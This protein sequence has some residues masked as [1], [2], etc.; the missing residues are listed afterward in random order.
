MLTLF[1]NIVLGNIPK[2]MQTLVKVLV[3]IFPLIMW[4]I[5]CFGNKLILEDQQYVASSIIAT[6]FAQQQQQKVA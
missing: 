3:I 1:L 2:V 4:S 5:W 6:I